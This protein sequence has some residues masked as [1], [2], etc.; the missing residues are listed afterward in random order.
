MITWNY[1]KSVGTVNT[2]DGTVGVF[3]GEGSC[4]S[5]DSKPTAYVGNGSVLIEMDTAK[6]YFFDEQT[7]R[8][9]SW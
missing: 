5:T 1:R 8:W 2:A 7:I 3:Y 4:L 6:V 9:L